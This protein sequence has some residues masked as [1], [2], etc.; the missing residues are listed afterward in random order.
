MRQNRKSQNRGAVTLESAVVLLAFFVLVL[1]M[2][3]A[4]RFMSVHQTLADATREGARLAVTP[5]T[6]TPTLPPDTA[7]TNRVRA[8]LDSNG[9]QGASVTINRNLAPILGSGTDRYTEVRASIQ[10]QVISLAMFSD[11]SITVT[12]A[13]KMRNETSP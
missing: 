5:L 2:M 13:S 7:I 3:E 11:L 6:Q 9:L 8:F 12:G 4:S 10:Y 1:G